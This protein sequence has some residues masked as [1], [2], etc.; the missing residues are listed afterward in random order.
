MPW[1]HILNST[2]CPLCNFPHLHRSHAFCSPATCSSVL[3][4]IVPFLARISLSLCGCHEFISCGASTPCGGRRWWRRRCLGVFEF[5]K[6]SRGAAPRTC[7]ASGAHY[8]AKTLVFVSF[9]SL[10][11][12]L[13]PRRVTST[14]VFVPLYRCHF[15]SFSLFRFAFLF[16]FFLFL[17]CSGPQCISFHLILQ[18]CD[19]TTSIEQPIV[20]A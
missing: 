11:V 13:V 17:W 12:L 20:A 9:S 4:S 16:L 1:R 8:H 18:G 2:H 15:F 5:S 6:C 3:D 19:D 7:S 14:S 10:P